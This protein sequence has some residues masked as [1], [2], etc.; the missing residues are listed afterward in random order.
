[1]KKFK[2]LF[3]S[4]KICNVIRDGARKIKRDMNNRTLPVVKKKKFVFFCFWIL[5]GV[6]E[7]QKHKIKKKF[8]SMKSKGRG[9]VD[10]KKF[11]NSSR[12]ASAN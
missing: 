5:P 7:A 4:L 10:R 12:M 1:M 9:R 11:Q 3:E 6:E 2:L 8:S